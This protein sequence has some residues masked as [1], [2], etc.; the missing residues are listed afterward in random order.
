MEDIVIRASEKVRKE[1]NN[2]KKILIIIFL[3]EM[4]MTILNVALQIGSIDFCRGC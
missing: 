2:G 3:F 1:K 4:N